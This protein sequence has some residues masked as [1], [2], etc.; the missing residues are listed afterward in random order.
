MPTAKVILEN[1]FGMLGI[2]FWSFQL[3][4]QVVSNY[5]AK[6]TQGLS[7]TM[8]LLWTLA[9]VGFGSYSIVQEL[10]IP[11]ILQPHLFGFLSTTCFMQCLYYRQQKAAWSGQK[12]WL[13]SVIVF[14]VL[15]GMEVGAV[16]ATLVK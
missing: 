13:I 14:L 16:F 15:A 11:I 7:A 8:F 12:T 4:P 2:V 1:V 10:S 3:L 6:T 5:K 9:S